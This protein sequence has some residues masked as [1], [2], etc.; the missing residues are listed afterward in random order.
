MPRAPWQQMVIQIPAPVNLQ[1]RKRSVKQTFF[2]HDISIELEQKKTELDH[3]LHQMESL[4]LEMPN[5]PHESVPSGTSELDNQEIRQ[6]GIGR[7]SCR[8]R[9]YVL[10]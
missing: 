8:E 2:Q 9:V 5:I 1:K 10:V 7:A 3:V 4:M 6:W